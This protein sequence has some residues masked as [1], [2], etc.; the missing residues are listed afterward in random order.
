[1][2]DRSEAALMRAACKYVSILDFTKGLGRTDSLTVAGGIAVMEP[3]RTDDWE[4]SAV[5]RKESTV[6]PGT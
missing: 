3:A 5:R 2:P 4:L 6:I 1:M